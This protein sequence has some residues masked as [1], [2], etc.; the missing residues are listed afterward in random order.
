MKGHTNDRD[1]WVSNL[2]VGSQV[3]V[4]TQY[5]AKRSKLVRET[6]HY[7]VT[8]ANAKFRKED[9][10]APGDY[11]FSHPRPY[12]N[13][14][15]FDHVRRDLWETQLRTLRNNIKSALEALERAPK[16]PTTADYLLTQVRIYTRALEAV[17]Y[18]SPL[19]DADAG[20]SRG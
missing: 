8:A 15:D 7:W 2:Q 18:Y 20:E 10:K 9:A 3:A 5:G 17:A 6:K 11:S 13:N 4:I 1:Q 16:D 14:P 12:L 19:A